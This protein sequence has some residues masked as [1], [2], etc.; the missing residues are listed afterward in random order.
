MLLGKSAGH[1]A[2]LFSAQVGCYLQ[3]RES[4]VTISLKLQLFVRAEFVVHFF[5]DFRLTFLSPCV[6]ESDGSLIIALC[7]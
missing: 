7:S 6:V 4:H 5:L 2:K 1:S 3:E